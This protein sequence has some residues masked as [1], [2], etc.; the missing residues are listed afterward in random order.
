MVADILH[1]ETEEK[2]KKVLDGYRGVPTDQPPFVFP[3]RNMGR[4]EVMGR[5]QK[6][7]DLFEAVRQ[8]RAAYEAAVEEYRRGLAPLRR[9][10]ADAMGVAQKHFGSDPA[11]MA[12]FGDCTCSKPKRRRPACE[13]NVGEEVVT[14]VTET[15]IEETTTTLSCGCPDTGCSCSES[16][17]PTRTRKPVHARKPH[18]RRRGSC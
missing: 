2:V 15:V 6:G 1:I 10:H 5:L 9:F 12:R 4:E 17:V 13:R 16:K 14:T 7:L 18:A 3:E 8:K 11:A